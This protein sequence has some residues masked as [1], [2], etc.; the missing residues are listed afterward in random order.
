MDLGKKIIN[1]RKKEK[2][3]QEKLA[4]VIGVTRQTISNWELNVTKPDL[5]Q[6]KELSKVF[7]ISIDELVDN[8]VKNV[9]IEKVNKTEKV[10]NKN[11]KN[12]RVLVITI[13][14]IILLSIIFL[15]IH[16]LTKKDFTKDYQAEF[17]CTNKETTF[18]VSVWA[19]ENDFSS[20]EDTSDKD[21]FENLNNTKYYIEISEQDKY[22][23]VYNV[24]ERY[25]AGNSLKEVFDSLEIVKK[26]MIEEY[27]AKCR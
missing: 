11:T 10:V 17:Y 2:I 25:P 5:K 18:N 12:I 27:N 4:D 19:T 13:Y 15:T 20:N 22:T 9:I 8:D 1:L 24:I 16:I 23:S 21:F 3:T 6:I 14:F 26:L 7:H